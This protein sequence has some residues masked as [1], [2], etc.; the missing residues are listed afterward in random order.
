MDPSSNADPGRER[1]HI[2]HWI[3]CLETAVPPPVTV[4]SQYNLH[5][6][7]YSYTVPSGTTFPCSVPRLDMFARFFGG[8]G[9][10]EFEVRVIWLDA[11]GGPRRLEVYGPVTVTFQPSV[12]VRDFSFRL[13]NVPLAGPG[14]YEIR[15]RMLNPRRT[16]ATEF[17]EVVEA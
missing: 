13:R 7:C 5:G 1:L 14:R 8:S 10:T 9:P 2:Q 16:L 15:L 4:P 6:V 17:L 3:A 12:P 11:P